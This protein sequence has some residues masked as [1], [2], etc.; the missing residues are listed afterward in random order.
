MKNKITVTILSLAVVSS[1]TI[2]PTFLQ[3]WICFAILF[4]S[5]AML[6]SY[7]VDMYNKHA[8]A[9]RLRDA[10]LRTYI[11]ER[12]DDL[13]RFI[14]CS[15][16]ELS[17][18]LSTEEELLDKIIERIKVLSAQ[19][20]YNSAQITKEIINQIIRQS[21]EINAA[22]KVQNDSIVREIAVLSGSTES[23]RES[24]E[25]TNKLYVIIR[26]ILNSAGKNAG[27]ET[28]TDEETKNIVLN[29]YTDGNLARS[30][31]KNPSG[32][33]IYELEYNTGKISISRNYDA[34]GRMN[35]EQIFYDDG[36][37]HYRNEFTKTGMKTTEFDNQGNIK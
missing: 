18:A 37:V 8:E 32:Q 27:I 33:I 36:Q 3:S 16:N 5:M 14:E 19:A 10:E 34:E 4:V 7:L 30:I 25:E 26:A 22:S 13:S 11:N 29:H 31:L 28:I 21:E 20:D 9:A 23:I 15:R 12:F 24:V 1:V 2:V 6:V 17:K 35:I